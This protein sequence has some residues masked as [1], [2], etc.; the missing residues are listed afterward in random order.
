MERLT[1]RNSDGSVSQP[2]NLRWADALR[3]LADYE[4]T[5]L[6]PGDLRKLKIKNG[7]WLRITEYQGEGRKR[8][9]ISHRDICSVCKETATA[10]SSFWDNRTPYCPWCGAVMTNADYEDEE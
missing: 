8:V 1:I 7:K 5:G 4:D 2:M 9:E 3:K 10:G 6:E